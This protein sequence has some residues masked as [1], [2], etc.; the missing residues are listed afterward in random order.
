MR[1]EVMRPYGAVAE[2]IFA[3]RC[4]GCG[5]CVAACPQGIVLIAQDGKAQ[6]DLARG[7]CTFCEK[8]ITACPAGALVPEGRADWTWRAEIAD[9]CL[10]FQGVTCRACEDFCDPRAIRFRLE[11]GGRALPQIDGAACT[12]CGACAG[13]CPAGAITFARKTLQQGELTA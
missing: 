5:D 12:G 13:G 4:D 2:D 9:D 11:T 3:R 6:V 7:E 1:P 10:A 8:C